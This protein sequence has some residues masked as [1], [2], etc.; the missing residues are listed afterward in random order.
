MDFNT[1]NKGFNPGYG[2][3]PFVIPSI[4]QALSALS[5]SSKEFHPNDT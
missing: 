5:N 4:G 1:P 3:R 2:H